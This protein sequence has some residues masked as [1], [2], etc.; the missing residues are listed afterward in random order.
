MLDIAHDATV[1][2]EPTTRQSGRFMLWA[3]PAELLA[4]VVAVIPV[5]EIP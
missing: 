4:C 5:T 1:L 2:L 3:E